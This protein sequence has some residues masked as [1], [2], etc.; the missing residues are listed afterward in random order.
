MTLVPDVGNEHLFRCEQSLLTV[1]ERS[2]STEAVD[3]SVADTVPL[4]S[5]LEA[6]FRVRLATIAG[7]LRHDGVMLI[8]NQLDNADSTRAVAIFSKLELCSIQ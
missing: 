5:T 4:L 2:C 8:V 6:K 3:T 1:N 7:H